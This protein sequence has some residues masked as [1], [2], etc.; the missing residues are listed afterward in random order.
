LRISAFRDRIEG[1][2][3]LLSLEVKTQPGMIET[4]HVP[5]LASICGHNN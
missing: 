3:G 2:G 4:S 1:T 5:E